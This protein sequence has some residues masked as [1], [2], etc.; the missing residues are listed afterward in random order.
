MNDEA[1]TTPQP[2]SVFELLEENPGISVVRG[3]LGDEL[4]V[5]DVAPEDD[6]IEPKSY[7]YLLDLRRE[8]ADQ[9]KPDLS[10]ITYEYDSTSDR[11]KRGIISH[12]TIRVRSDKELELE[13]LKVKGDELPPTYRVLRSAKIGVQMFLAWMATRKE[14]RWNVPNSRVYDWVQG[15][16]SRLLD[17]EGLVDDLSQEG[18]LD[19]SAYPTGLEI[20]ELMSKMLEA[21]DTENEDQ[22]PE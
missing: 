8:T 20:I 1:I 13:E 17:P 19:P 22:I 4:T 21:V 2:K 9:V 16:N 7:V 10:V 14:D 12:I 11:V 6:Q 15:D 5:Y 3:R 18:L